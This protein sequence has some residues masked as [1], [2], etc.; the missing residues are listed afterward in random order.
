MYTTCLDFFILDN[1]T[2]LL[3]MCISDLTYIATQ[4]IVFSDNVAAGDITPPGYNLQH[5][6]RVF[7][8]GSG[9]IGVITIYMPGRQCMVCCYFL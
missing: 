4:N 3:Y 5:I 7:F 8:W 9:G 6:L 2:V 1:T